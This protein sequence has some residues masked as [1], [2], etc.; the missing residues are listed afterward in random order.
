M[1]PDLHEPIF[2]EWYTSAELLATVCE[3]VGAHEDD[4]QL[5]LFNL[6]VNPRQI[7][8]SLVW[9]RDNVRYA[10]LSDVSKRGINGLKID[11]KQ[12]RKRN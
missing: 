12:K 10:I 9:H 4:L 1:H 2:L 6:L 3:I 8:Y 7:P 11:P 5:E